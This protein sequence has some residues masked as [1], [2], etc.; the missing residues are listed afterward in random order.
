[1]I[2]EPIFEIMAKEMPSYFRRA[3]VAKYTQDL[4]Q[5]STLANMNRAGT[6]PTPHMMGRTVVYMKSEFLEWL[7]AYYGGMS[8]EFNFSR[9]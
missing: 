3:D 1:M 6:G 4:L 8:D 7:R 2:S 9:K 5:A